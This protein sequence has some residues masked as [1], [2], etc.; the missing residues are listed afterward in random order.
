MAQISEMVEIENIKDEH[1]NLI[2]TKEKRTTR[3]VEPSGEPDYIKLYTKM[4]CEF[5][6]IPVAY[7]NLFLELA[8][9]MSYTDADDLDN[10]QTVYTGKPISTT[11]C[12]RL[13][14]KERMYLKGLKALCDCKAIKRVNR[15]FYQINPTYAGR[16]TWKYNPKLQQ[17]GIEKLVATFD[18]T[19][20]TVDTNAVFAETNLCTGEDEDGQ[21]TQV[22]TKTES[23][24]D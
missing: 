13:G 5:N 11:I 9:R 20:G 19:E 2:D 12:K 1:G 18:F 10:S 14:W 8:L 24:E 22:L 16:G 4:W 17:G 3:K 15:G 7:R 21:V 6:G 23:K